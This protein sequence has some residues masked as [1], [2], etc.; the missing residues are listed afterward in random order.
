MPIHRFTTILSLLA[1]LLAV[2]C[3]NPKGESVIEPSHTPFLEAP[4][5]FSFN[6]VRSSNGTVSL[7]WST[8]SRAASYRVFYGTAANDIT[9]AVPAC[10]GGATSCSITGLNPATLYYFS[11]QSIN[12]AGPRNISSSESALS[13]GTFDITSS[14]TGLGFV[15]VSWAAA[16]AATSYNVL[17]G[18]SPGSYPNSANGV[19]SP[20]SI[21]GLTT[22][23]TY[24]V[25]V[26]AVNNQNG[27]SQSTSEAV[28]TTF[29]PPVAPTGLAA[30]SSP[31]SVA[32]TWN[33]VASA[34]NYKVYRGLTAGSLAQIASGVVGTSYTDNTV[35]NGTTYFYAVSTFNGAD[36]ALST[37]VSTRPIG[38]FSLSPVA[39]HSATS[40]E[41]TWGNA[42]GAASY[43]IRYGT[44][45]SSYTVTS[46]NRASPFILTGLNPATT[47]YFIVEA[48]NTV[49]SGTTVQSNE[50]T[51]V[52]S[53]ATPSI[54]ITVAGN[55]SNATLQ[56][57]P[58]MPA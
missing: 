7:S 14:S 27:Y 32:L 52:T 33:P 51:G 31:S 47:Y 3:N 34:T 11:V 37:S 39:T 24:Y 44:S 45:S 35:S 17:W 15:N 22:G 5:A 49:G 2:A 58:I 1:L 10:T 46:S 29:G 53:S 13:V 9:T 16:S 23:T 40:V 43:D 6:Q 50:R 54:A 4:G 12:A 30:V 36:S 21:T 8:S 48:T 20:Y 41:L 55:I 19:V 42:T 57:L 25:R 18:T 28:H 26:V 56:R 38:T